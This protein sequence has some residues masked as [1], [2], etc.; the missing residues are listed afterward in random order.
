M[1]V[2]SL[3]NEVNKYRSVTKFLWLS[4]HHKRM[5]LSFSEHD[6]LDHK[7]IFV[8]NRTSEKYKLI[9]YDIFISNS[10]QFD[11]GDFD[12]LKI[13]FEL[14]LEVF[15]NFGKLIELIEFLF[16]LLLF[17]IEVFQVI[18]LEFVHIIFHFTDC[19]Y[20]FLWGQILK[21]FVEVFLYG[22]KHFL[23]FLL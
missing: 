3:T 4:C 2:D 10:L 23:D 14:F 17:F 21:F 9:V 1:F 16:D 15:I 6:F 8:H 20:F 11:L 7:P 18:Y 19:L 22:K 12:F 5:P 13:C